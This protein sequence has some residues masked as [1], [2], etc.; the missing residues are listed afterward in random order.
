M[1]K[2]LGQREVTMAQ[3][4]NSG[5]SLTPR[6]QVSHG[7]GRIYK[8]GKKMKSDFLSNL[9]RCSKAGPPGRG[10]PVMCG[11][12]RA[13]V[14]FPSAARRSGGAHTQLC[15]GRRCSH[16]QPLPRQLRGLPVGVK[17]KLPPARDRAVSGVKVPE[18]SGFPSAPQPLGSPPP[19]RGKKARTGKVRRRL[20]LGLVWVF[21]RRGAGSLG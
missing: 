2:W 13:T 19:K 7:S 20:G 17:S 5:I 16:P 11:G 9:R 10:W 18:A 21:E 3:T 12:A 8:W 15:T 4:P 6:K 1:I 14:P